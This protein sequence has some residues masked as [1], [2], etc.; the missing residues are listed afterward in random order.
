[1]NEMDPMTA[2]RLQDHLQLLSAPR[3]V[4]GPGQ[5]GLSRRSRL[6]GRRGG[7]PPAGPA[8]AQVTTELAHQQANARTDAREGPQG[9]AGRRLEQAR[10]KVESAGLEPGDRDAL[11]R[12]VDRAI[13]EIRQFVEQ[14]RPRIEL[15]EKNDHVRQDID[16]EQKTKVQM[17]QKLAAMVDEY[18]RLHGRAAL[19]RGGGARQAGRRTGPQGTGR[20]A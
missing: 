20:A 4:A 11:L 3:T 17:Q 10:K 15:A 19:R 5:P 7:G 12:R 13:T 2:Q 14:N 6:A 1:M 9:G 18:N 16:R 8:A